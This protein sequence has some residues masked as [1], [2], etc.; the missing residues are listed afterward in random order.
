LPNEPNRAPIRGFYPI[1]DTAACSRAGVRPEALAEALAAAR[2]PIAQFRHKGPFTR[3]VFSQAAHIGRV[4]QAAGVVYVVNDRA[5]VALLLGAGG[6]HLGQQDLPP[7]QV[8]GMVG[9][10]LWIGYST[11]NREQL[12]A[13]DREPVDYLA[14]GPIF[15]TG[16]KQNPDPA[17]GLEALAAARR[18]SAKPLVAIGGIT[19][20]NARSALAAGAGAVAVI[21]D[22]LGEN[23]E[24]R[25]HQWMEITNG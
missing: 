10:S 14:F 3:E 20:A 2:V 21:S 17:V 4:L 7:S 19:R 24:A 11:H 25:I 12:L 22:L 18:L 16:S 9:S 6:I 15:P 23:L 8:R 13:G 5:D 1:I